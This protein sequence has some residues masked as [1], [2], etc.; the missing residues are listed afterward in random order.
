MFRT[1]NTHESE[2][3]G[4]DRTKDRRPN[5]LTVSHPPAHPPAHQFGI[6]QNPD[7]PTATPPALSPAIRAIP[8]SENLAREIKD[9][10]LSGFVGHGTVITGDTSF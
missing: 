10:N 5:E 1:G 7:A 4:L 2:Q 8:E 9:G 6:P 3:A